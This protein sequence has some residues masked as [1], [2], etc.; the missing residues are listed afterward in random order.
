[1]CLHALMACPVHPICCW[2]IWVPFRDPQPSVLFRRLPLFWHFLH[3]LCSPIFS[4]L[5]IPECLKMGPP[6][7]PKITKTKKGKGLP[8]N[9]PTVKTC[10][11]TQKHHNF[12]TFLHD[13]LMLFQ[14]KFQRFFGIAGM[15][16]QLQKCHLDSLFAMFAACRR[17]CRNIEKSKKSVSFWELFVQISHRILQRPRPPKNESKC[18]PKWSLWALEIRKI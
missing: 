4:S 2:A 10:K 5:M 6:Q 3:Q 17:F 9:A 1:M 12:N 13:F 14:S 16:S 18:L 8:Q 7:L 11:K 15:T